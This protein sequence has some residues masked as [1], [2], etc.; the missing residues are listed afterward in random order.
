MRLTS[1]A[2]AIALAAP[3]LLQGQQ[4][5]TSASGVAALIKEEKPGLKARAKITADAAVATA[6]KAAPSGSSFNEGELEEERGKLIYSL[7]FKVPGSTVIK[8]V[9]VDAVS[10]SIVG[11]EDEEDDKPGA[12]APRRKDGENDKGRKIRE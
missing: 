7:Q 8:E 11:V 2:L 10:G 4:V 9:N 6:M 12:N 1:L 5:G 3:T